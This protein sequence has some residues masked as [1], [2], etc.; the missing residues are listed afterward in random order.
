MPEYRIRRDGQQYLVFS[1]SLAA[2]ASDRLRHGQEQDRWTDIRVYRTDTGSYV[3]EQV[4]RTL[5]QKGDAV[6]YQGDLCP[7]PQDVYRAL[8]GLEAEPPLG[9]L[10]KDLLHQLAAQDPRFTEPIEER[11]GSQD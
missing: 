2:E 1:G 10:E 6:W 9:N 3:V 8:V 5:W 7:T 11:D 4:M